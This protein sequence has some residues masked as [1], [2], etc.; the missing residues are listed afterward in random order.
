MVSVRGSV[1]VGLL[2][3]SARVGAQE[4]ASP[5][6]PADPG[7]AALQP[8][9]AERPETGGRPAP[10]LQVEGDGFVYR[11]GPFD[12]HIRSDGRLELEDHF[13][14]KVGIP[15]LQRLRLDLRG[16]RRSDPEP[17]VYG[18]A[19]DDRIPA[20]VPMQAPRSEEEEAARAAVPTDFLGEAEAARAQVAE[21][22]RDLRLDLPVPIPVPVISFDFDAYELFMRAVG[23]DAHPFQRLWIL[24][25]TESLRDRLA[26]ASRAEDLRRSMRDLRPRLSR[27]W[28]D[29]RR[30]APARRREIFEAWDECEEGTPEGEGAREEIESFVRDRLPCDGTDA[31]SEDELDVLNAARESEAPFDPYADA[32]PSSAR[33]GAP[34]ASP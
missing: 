6:P 19:S 17:P 11:G 34:P 24:N 5:A 31:Y 10:T 4:P 30:P 2:L 3:L 12:A 9:D 23:E 29:R 14:V 16:P 21:D 1:V 20:I 13:P 15:L 33:P 26:D 8:L 22:G 27:I 18:D 25:E 28:N 32:T 7:E